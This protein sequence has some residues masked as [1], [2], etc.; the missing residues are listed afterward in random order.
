MTTTTMTTTATTGVKDV[1]PRPRMYEGET[2]SDKIK[3]ISTQLETLLRE[4]KHEGK[5]SFAVVSVNSEYF[6]FQRL[7]MEQLP[8]RF[9]DASGRQVLIEPARDVVVAGNKT[10]N[11]E[12]KNYIADA[13]G[14][15][16]CDEKFIVGQYFLE[17]GGGGKV[18]SKGVK[19]LVSYNEARQLIRSMKAVSIGMLSGVALVVGISDLL[20]QA[21]GFLGETKV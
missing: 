17:G 15:I 8:V 11:E 20:E 14:N 13:D 9:L 5:D 6:S 7:L 18:R 1:S 16:D 3:R 12:E 2:E 4:K 10:K 19:R 21:I